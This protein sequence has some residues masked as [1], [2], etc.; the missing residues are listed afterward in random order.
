MHWNVKSQDGLALL[1]LSKIHRR[2]PY[3]WV[4]F[5][6]FVISF[7]LFSVYAFQSLLTFSQLN[8]VY[9]CAFLCFISFLCFF[10]GDLPLQ[11][12]VGVVTFHVW[13]P[14]MLDLLLCECRTH[15]VEV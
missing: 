12:L 13:T 3:C 9:A 10:L 4:I 1:I 7:L 5:H 8:V 2:M 14:C 6:L 11:S 15:D